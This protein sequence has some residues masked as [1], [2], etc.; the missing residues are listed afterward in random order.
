MGWR[1]ERRGE[2]CTVATLI[3]ETSGKKHSGNTIARSFLTF[4]AQHLYFQVITKSITHVPVIDPDRDQ[5]VEITRQNMT[6]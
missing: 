5:R 6:S 2:E 1:R 3:E 4:I